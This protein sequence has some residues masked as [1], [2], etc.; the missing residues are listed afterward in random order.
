MYA[1]NIYF[2][3]KF[4]QLDIGKNVYCISTSDHRVSSKHQPLISA[5]AFGIFLKYGLSFNK[6]RQMWLLLK[7]LLYCTVM[8]FFV[9]CCTIYLH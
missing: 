2:I 3:A 4:I 9:Y 7:V 5:V 1:K 8:Y 6:L